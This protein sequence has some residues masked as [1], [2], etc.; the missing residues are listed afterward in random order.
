M[1]SYILQDT[2]SGYKTLL[3]DNGREIRIHSK[4]DPLMEAERNAAAFDP[5][6]AGII[7]V[8]GLGLGYH[9]A[10]LISRF[11]ESLVIVIEKDSEV[12]ELAQSVNAKLLETIRTVQSPKDLDSIF[13]ELDLTAFT[14]TAVYHHRPSYTLD[15]EFYDGIIAETGRYISS[16]LSDLLTRF[17]FEEKW[18]ENIFS[19]IKALYTSAPV[20]SLFGKFK[21]YPGIIVSAG[22]S[23][24]NNVEILHVAKDRALIVCVDTA[25]KILLHHKIHPHIVM[26]LDAQKHSIKHFLG[27]PETN[28]VLLADM[29]SFPSIL[30]T[31]RGRTMVSTTA[32]YYS[33]RDGIMKREAT[34][35]INWI[36]SYA[37]PVGDIQS[38]GSVATNVFDLLLNL[39]CSSI[40]LVGQDL[41]YTGREIHCSG[42]H[43]NESWIPGINRFTTLDSIN[44]GV[45][46]K[47]KIKHVEAFGGAGTVISDYVFDLYRGWF[48]DSAQKVSLDVI[49]ATEGGARIRNTIEM[50]LAMAI[51]EMPA[52]HS[53]PEQVINRALEGAQSPAPEKLLHNIHAAIAELQ[54]LRQLAE[55]ENRNS[56]S[57][58][59][60]EVQARLTSFTMRELLSP[61][62]KR[63][64]VYLARKHDTPPEKATSMVY[65]DIV[66]ASEKV[67]RILEKAEHLLSTP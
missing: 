2:R 62:L 3:Y 43:H 18:I 39:G 13:E 27:I 64:F 56:P 7:V 6:R 34:P 26:T 65:R 30:R 4:Y 17:E 58:I 12:I 23:L 52:R 38:G 8:C 60:A 37:E 24:K 66:S 36:E 67:I 14:G 22:P 20:K 28:S 40:I 41:A 50:T 55:Q 33:G 9:A 21:G 19:N 11:P 42:T 5:G 15:R 45:I 57:S 54:E 25:L 51:R 59:T 46:R 10:A 63:T 29:V 47:R 44:Q 1:G 16:K 35:A 53:T 31:Y 32:K 48:E 61:F 49:N